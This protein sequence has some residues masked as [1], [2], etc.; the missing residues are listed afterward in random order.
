MDTH[1]QDMWRRSMG[2]KEKGY[3]HYTRLLPNM[4]QQMAPNSRSAKALGYN[5]IQTYLDRWELGFLG[6]A[7]IA[8]PL[9]PGL[10]VTVVIPPPA[11]CVRVRPFAGPQG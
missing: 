5:G 11:K 9:V 3:R 7:S 10:V 6:S 2:E 8:E 1:S 4:D